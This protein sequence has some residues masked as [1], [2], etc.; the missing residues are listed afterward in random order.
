MDT[1][2][3]ANSV[4]KKYGQ[5]NL[6]STI[7]TIAIAIVGIG[8]GYVYIKS[9]IKPSVTVKEIDYDLGV[10][11]LIVA[12]KEKMLYG[13]STISAGGE[14]GIR[15]GNSGVDGDHDNF[16]TLQ[17]V[18]NQIVYEWLAIKSKVAA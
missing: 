12:G 1:L 10:A 16:D 11:K 8:A 14:W 18:K 5:I 9:V 13:F 2:E 17:L 7:A 4:I 3:K 6:L 15:F